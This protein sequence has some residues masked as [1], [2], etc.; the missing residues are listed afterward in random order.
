MAPIWL[1]ITSLL[2]CSPLAAADVECDG[3][4]FELSECAGTPTM[5]L[6][7]S[8]DLHHRPHRPHHHARWSQQPNA[9]H[10]Q[11]AVAVLCL[12]V[13]AFSAT[14][15]YELHQSTLAVWRPS[16]LLFR[17]PPELVGGQFEQKAF[18]EV[19]ERQAALKPRACG[20]QSPN[21]E[22]DFTTTTVELLAVGALAVVCLV[23]SAL[24]LS[25]AKPAWHIEPAAGQ[26]EAS[27]ML[28]ATH[29]STRHLAAYPGLTFMLCISL[30][31]ILGIWYFHRVVDDRREDSHNS[32]NGFSVR[33]N[34]CPTAL[35][36]VFSVLF[37]WFVAFAMEANPGS[38][39]MA[40]ESQAKAFSFALDSKEKRARDAKV[41]LLSTHTDLKNSSVESATA[42]AAPEPASTVATPAESTP[43]LVPEVRTGAMRSGKVKS[44][45]PEDCNLAVYGTSPLCMFSLEFSILCDKIR[46][47]VA[48]LADNKDADN[49]HRNNPGVRFHWH[50]LWAPLYVICLLLCLI[51]FGRGCISGEYWQLARPRQFRFTL[52]KP[53]VLQQEEQFCYQ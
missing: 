26:K 51:C 47:F 24:L 25:Y 49:I 10:S 20:M 53:T 44:P 16:N 34:V 13:L 41:V 42:A 9:S 2:C 6:Q 28:N 3:E 52:G 46:A 43:V 31:L 8:L 35:A 17:E 32:S 7:T 45:Y 11:V 15:L 48:F 39:S 4:P 33:C 38:V 50:W 19:P 18:E 21:G 12:V 30:P 14:L 1:V 5:L 23:I 29:A 37:M 36:L 22:V 27:I 40:A